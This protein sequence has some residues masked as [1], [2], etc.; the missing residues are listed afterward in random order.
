MVPRNAGLC[1]R[2]EFRVD[3][4]T[5]ARSV[6]RTWLELEWTPPEEEEP[7]DE[8]TAARAQAEMLAAHRATP[9]L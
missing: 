5:G 2:T 1:R 8:E 9:G 3:P 7:W 4:E 6:I